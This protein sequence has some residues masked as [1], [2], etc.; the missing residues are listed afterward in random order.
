M[1]HCK[2]CG[3]WAGVAS[4]EHDDCAKLA[5]EGKTAEEIR[6]LRDAPPLAATPRPIT[7]RS[8]FWSVFFAL[9]AFSL[10]AAIVFAI[11]RA[12]ISNL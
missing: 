4:D 5:A 3:Q 10:T 2:H 12:V 8:I 1:A 7:T 6:Y 11:I 9:W